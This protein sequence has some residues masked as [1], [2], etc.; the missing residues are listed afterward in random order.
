MITANRQASLRPSPEEREESIGINP[1]QP[2][3]KVMINGMEYFFSHYITTP[4][5][6]AAFFHYY[7]EG[8]Q[9]GYIKHDLTKTI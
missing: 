7:V 8:R 1:Y 4:T 3:E 6:Q 5:G 9:Y 2:N